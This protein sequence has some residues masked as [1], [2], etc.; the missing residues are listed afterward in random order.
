TIGVGNSYHD[1][2]Q[3]GKSHLEASTA[4]HYKLIKGANQI[5]FFT[6]T[7]AQHLSL[8]WYDKRMI[9]QLELFLRQKDKDRVDEI[10]DQIVHIIKAE[11]TNLFMAKCL[12][13]DVSST[14]MRIVH[15]MRR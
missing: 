4:L 1:F 9:E 12:S 3:I 14:V 2:T 8:R 10:I 7:S 11:D 5:I 15:D 13:F 6:E